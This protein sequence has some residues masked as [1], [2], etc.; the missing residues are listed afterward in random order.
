[1]R[2]VYTIGLWSLFFGA[3]LAPTVSQATHV[4]AGEITT[5]RI[6]ATSLTYEITFTAYFDEVKGKPAADQATEYT[7]CFG[8]GTTAVV[9]RQEPRTYI[10]GRTSSINIYKIVHTYP[11][12]GAYTI[13]ITVPNRNK[14]T[15]NLPP[16]GDSD[17]I[18]FFVSTT[19]LINANLGLNS[20]PRMLNPPLDSG[21]VNQKFCHNPAA[22]DPDGD[23]LAFRLSIPKTSPTDAGC[24]GRDIP[25]YQDP[26]RF[27][28]TSEAGGTPTFTI[29][30]STG[31][32]CWDAPGQEGQYNFAFIVEEW[33][34]GVLIGEITRDMQIIVVDNLNKRPLLSTP[35]PT[36]ASRRV[37]SSTNLSRPPIP[38]A[39]GSSSRA[40][41]VS[42]MWVRMGL[43][44]PRV[45]LFSLPTLV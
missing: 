34:N 45:N 16:P 22:F 39:S 10:N 19:I 25:A 20:T 37:R 11:G 44:C 8:D 9:K 35:S 31:E 24:Q 29:N 42:S 33:R 7:M 15:K 38:M 40:L 17:Q 4:R 23:S 18:R 41:G 12:P 13:G 3:M 1:M 26:T 32:L 27:S 21:R 2:L 43:P 28:T 14:D 36:S 6:S 30:P 5:R